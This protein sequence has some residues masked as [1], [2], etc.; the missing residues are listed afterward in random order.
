[1]VFIIQA[2]N[3]EMETIF[4]NM[5]DLHAVVS[6]E[7]PVG[8]RPSVIPDL[9]LYLLL[10]HHVFNVHVRAIVPK[11]N[12]MVGREAVMLLLLL[13]RKMLSVGEAVVTRVVICRR[14]MG[15]RF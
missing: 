9:L 14:Q 3:P 2:Y 15:H 13:L 11:S 1:M 6:T 7:R 12:C 8:R 10:A 4:L 5:R